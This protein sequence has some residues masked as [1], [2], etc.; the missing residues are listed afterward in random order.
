M[1]MFKTL[2]YKMVLTLESVNDILTHDFSMK[3]TEKYFFRNTV[4]YSLQDGS[5][6][7]DE[8]L[9]CDHSDESY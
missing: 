3:A 1:V 7:E 2:L 6:L 5:K 9:E 8:F 4:H